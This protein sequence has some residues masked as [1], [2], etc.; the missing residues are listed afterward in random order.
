MA[1]T[2]K[3]RGHLVPV[4]KCRKE[5]YNPVGTGNSWT[6]ERHSERFTGQ[7][8]AQVKPGCES[9]SVEASLW[10]YTYSEQKFRTC[11]QTEQRSSY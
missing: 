6:T 9:V 8:K 4:G 3:S 10:D 1:A 11:L 2:I 7:H 5:L